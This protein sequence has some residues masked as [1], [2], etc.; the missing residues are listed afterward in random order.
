MGVD[1]AHEVRIVA[2]AGVA[3]HLAHH[4]IKGLAVLVVAAHA[5]GSGLHAV[6]QGDDVYHDAVR[7]AGI[8]KVGGIASLAVVP[9]VVTQGG[10]VI[11]RQLGVEGEVFESHL[12]VALHDLELLVGER[13][14]VVVY[15]GD[16]GVLAQVVVEGGFAHKLD[17][18]ALVALYAAFGLATTSNWG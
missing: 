12:R 3:T 10:V 15:H 11:L 9:L 1:M 18:P 7:R 4:G 6:A 16:D 8:V 5:L 14:V 2:G 13:T 17:E